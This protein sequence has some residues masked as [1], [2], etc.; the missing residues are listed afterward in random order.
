VVVPVIV[1]PVINA[2]GELLHYGYILIHLEIPNPL[3]RWDV[4]AK[5]PFIKDAFIRE[6]HA[7]PNTMPGTTE[8]N[9]EDMRARLAKRVHALAGD[10]VGEVIF[11]DIAFPPN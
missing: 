5:I 1:L 11:K 4:E 7:A 6:L 9:V 3:D 10:H 8:L 2:R